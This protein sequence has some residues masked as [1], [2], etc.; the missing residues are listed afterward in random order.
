MILAKQLCRIFASNDSTCV[1]TLMKPYREKCT[2]EVVDKSFELVHILQNEKKLLQFF[3]PPC[4]VQ[5]ASNGTAFVGYKWVSNPMLLIVFKIDIVTPFVN[6]KTIKYDTSG[7]TDGYRVGSQ[8]NPLGD[9]LQHVKHL[10]MPCLFRRVQWMLPEK[11][12][13]CNSSYKIETIQGDARAI[14]VNNKNLGAIH[15]YAEFHD[16]HRIFPFDSV[17]PSFDTFCLNM[18]RLICARGNHW[19]WSETSTHDGI[20]WINNGY[21]HHVSY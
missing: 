16:D 4:I 6:Q 1:N 15:T 11:A 10:D 5:I 18:P 7:G 9:F 19:G 20:C 8:S 3:K 12:M 21:C 13:E 17:T 2:K 14:I